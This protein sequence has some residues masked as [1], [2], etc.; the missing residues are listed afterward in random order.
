MIHYPDFL[1]RGWD[2][3]SGPTE[4]TCK[5]LTA[6]LKHSGMRWHPTHAQGLANLTAL[7]QNQQWQTYWQTAA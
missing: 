3:G 4:A 7:H 5:T 6:R 1:A 2:I